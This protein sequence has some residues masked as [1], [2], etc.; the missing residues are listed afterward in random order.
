M[1]T[2]AL[3]A[4]ACL[5]GQA[6]GQT[7]E[8]VTGAPTY[9]GFSAPPTDTR[10]P[11]SNYVHLVLESRAVHVCNLPTNVSATCD[12]VCTIANKQEIDALCPDGHPEKT[13]AV[14]EAN[15]PASTTS[16]RD[17]ILDKEEMATIGKSVILR[18]VYI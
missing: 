9:P 15:R 12:K 7:V 10:D 2:V 16:F 14:W 5:F 8:N 17:F 4:A 1:K 18:G 11:L 3:I 13:L 6:Q